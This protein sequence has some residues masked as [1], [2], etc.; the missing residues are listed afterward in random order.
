MQLQLWYKRGGYTLQAFLKNC[1]IYL[2]YICLLCH[3]QDF[4]IIMVLWLHSSPNMF[5]LLILCLISLE[6][7]FHFLF[8]ILQSILLD[9]LHNF[10]CF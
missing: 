4:V 5:I 8:S 9:F 10:P 6:H 7:S 2:K 3:R 1:N